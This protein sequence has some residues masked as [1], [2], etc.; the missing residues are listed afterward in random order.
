M[1]E[2]QGLMAT[3]TV[4]FAYTGVSL[5]HCAQ[6]EGRRAFSYTPLIFNARITQR[7]V[8]QASRHSGSQ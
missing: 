4:V 6:Q 7:R 2:G 1:E 3:M 8:N 5:F